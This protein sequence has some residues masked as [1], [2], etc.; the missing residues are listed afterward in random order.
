MARVKMIHHV[1]VPIRDRHRTREWYEK[2][3]GAE[4]LDRGPE[5]N[6]RQ[7]QLRIGTGEMHFSDTPDLAQAPRVHFAV[8]IDNWN[9]MLARLD[10][11][12]VPHSRSSGANLGPART[13]E[14]DDFQ[15][16]REDNNE[17]F[18]YIN[19]PDGN[20]IELVYHPLG[21]E[22]SDGAEV[23][24]ADASK[25]LRWRQVPGFVTSS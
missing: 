6:K 2:V 18:T 10:A 13:P 23:D 24:L 11:L 22:D 14:D 19:D 12:G 3:L 9:E 5:L 15:G 20:L 17:H 16:R 21:L 7:L 1:N 4:F 25:G 8:E